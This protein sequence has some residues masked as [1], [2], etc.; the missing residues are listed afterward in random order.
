MHAYTQKHMRAHAYPSGSEK[1]PQF[2]QISSE[3]EKWE[4]SMLSVMHNKSSVPSAK[5]YNQRPRSDKNNSAVH[6]VFLLWVAVVWGEGSRVCTCKRPGETYETFNLFNA[7]LKVYC[8]LSLVSYRLW[9]VQSVKW[10]P[11]LSPLASTSFHICCI[12]LNGKK[13]QWKYLLPTR[14]FVLNILFKLSWLW[15]GS[16]KWW[17]SLFPCSCRESGVWFS[18]VVSVLW[19]ISVAQQP[20][21]G[22][23]QRGDW[24]LL[25]LKSWNTKT[26]FKSRPTLL[27][28]T[29][30]TQLQLIF[31]VIPAWHVVVHITPSLSTLVVAFTIFDSFWT[32]N[33]QTRLLNEAC[34][35]PI[36]VVMKRMRRSKSS[37]FP[38]N[39]L[40]I[41]C[42]QSSLMLWAMPRGTDYAKRI[43]SCTIYLAFASASTDN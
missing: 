26:H 17:W 27:M 7:N 32:P 33:P 35:S 24:C 9:R 3:L 18:S 16:E 43:H 41:M 25:P 28:L 36:T 13:M 14:L 19:Q 1:S 12:S 29:Y 31:P 42:L 5:P 20:V 10:V 15:L 8:C 22:T 2:V 40:S 23:V 11:R 6:A 37:F 4:F 39:E 38:L 21:E 30:S 34:Y